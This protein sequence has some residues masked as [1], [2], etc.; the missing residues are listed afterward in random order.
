MLKPIVLHHNIPDIQVAHTQGL[1]TERRGVSGGA[2]A[3]IPPGWK[4]DRTEVVILGRIV[5]AVI[6][7]RY[8]TIGLLSVYLHPQTEV[9]E[10]K[11][12][13]AWVKT[14]KVD[15]P[16]YMGE[17]LTRLIPVARTFGMNY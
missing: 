2:A 4:L 11:E 5:L 6:Q 13:I 9:V 16:L 8:S 3:L 14:S 10:L 1:L 12:L 15:F 17:T 7:E